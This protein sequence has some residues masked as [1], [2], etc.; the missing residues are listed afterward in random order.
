M[1]LSTLVQKKFSENTVFASEI[2]VELPSAAN[3]YPL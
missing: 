1:Q 2:H 3:K